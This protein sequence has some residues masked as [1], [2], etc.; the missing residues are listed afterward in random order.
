MEISKT[1]TSGKYLLVTGLADGGH[2]RNSAE[3][4]GYQIEKHLTFPDHAR[5]APAVMESILEE[6]KAQGLRIAMTGKDWVKWRPYVDSRLKGSMIE[7]LEPTV[8]LDQNDEKIWNQ[9]IWE[10]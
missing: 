3:R 9:V 4:A 2:A 6:A 8:Q 10:S 7:V 5:Y 1:E